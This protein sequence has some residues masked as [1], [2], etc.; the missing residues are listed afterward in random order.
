MVQRFLNAFPAE[1]PNRPDFDARA[2]NT[3]APQ[4]IDGIDGTL[5]IDRDLSAS[6]R[7]SA[8]YTINRQRTDA[9]QL[10]AGQNP[11]TDIHANR[12]RLAWRKA[13][14][15][16]T[17]LVIAGGFTRTVSLLTPEPNAV[18]PRV[19]FGFQIEELGPDSHFPTDRQLNA[20]RYGAQMSHIRGAHSFTW[21][22]DVTRY[23]LDG[24]ETN[25]ERGV[26]QFT[27]NFGRGSIENL[28]WG[29]P[30]T[31]EVTL[32]DVYREY[33]STSGAL[34]FG[35]RWRAGRRLQLHYG[36]RY[37]IR[38]SAAG[39]AR[40]RRHSLR[41]RLQQ[42]Q[43]ATWRCRGTAAWLGSADGRRG[44]VCAHPGGHVSAGAK[45]PTAASDRAALQPEPH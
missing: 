1:L 41:L 32:G 8:S 10:V 27:N 30:S 31:Y 26:Y 2:L 5:R 6:S 16:A 21:G 38:G 12:L 9:F 39:G 25:N 19:R 13:L 43:S 29:T 4:R 24:R 3:N 23:Q 17:E 35:D 20:F 33:R 11:D 7:L 28:R 15:P 45:Q 37:R 44:I 42:L 22:G 18:G 14:S 40:P 36:L 34:Y